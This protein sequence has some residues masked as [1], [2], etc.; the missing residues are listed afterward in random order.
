MSVLPGAQYQAGQSLSVTNN[1]SLHNNLTNSLPASV[2]SVGVM[3]A[4]GIVSNNVSESQVLDKKR[5]ISV[6][7]IFNSL[8]SNDRLISFSSSGSFG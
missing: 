6:L 3:G 8:F 1:T 2:N 4:Q 5:Y 7:T